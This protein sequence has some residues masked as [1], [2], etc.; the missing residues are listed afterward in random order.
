LLTDLPPISKEHDGVCQDALDMLD[1]RR[2]EGQHV[3]DALD[4]IA[5]WGG[6]E[7]AL[8]VD[9]DGW[10]I[11][12]FSCHGDR[13]GDGALLSIKIPTDR[14]QPIRVVTHDSPVETVV[15]ERKVLVT[16]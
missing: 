7:F 12:F 13:D 14:A 1:G 9:D 8:H 4:R 10:R 15:P 5:R 2:A 6:Q 3:Q 16:P 11:E